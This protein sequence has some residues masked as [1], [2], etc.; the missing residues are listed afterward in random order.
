MPTLPPK[1]GPTSLYVHFSSGRV[2]LALSSTL[3]NE[4]CDCVPTQAQVLV[5]PKGKCEGTLPTCQTQKNKAFTSRP[6][7]G[8]YVDVLQQENH[9]WHSRCNQSHHLAKFM[10][11]HCYS[12]RPTCLLHRPS[13]WAGDVIGIITL[14]SF[15]S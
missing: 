8:K 13:R 10:T 15:K 9:I 6:S 7:A 5:E 3:W 4:E 2:I 12:P 1:E 11:A 14:A